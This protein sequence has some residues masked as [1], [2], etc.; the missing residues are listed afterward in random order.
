MKAIS[1]SVFLTAFLA[2]ACIAEGDHGRLLR[3]GGKDKKPKHDEKY[4]VDQ[5]VSNLT[6]IRNQIA[7]IGGLDGIL[8]AL[9]T[10]QERAHEVSRTD[11]EGDSILSPLLRYLRKKTSSLEYLKQVTESLSS[12]NSLLLQL[13]SFGGLFSLLGAFMTGGAGTGTVD[14]VQGTTVIEHVSGEVVG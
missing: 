2:L 6:S 9:R 13:K 8:R 4:Y 1:T 7:P 5:I 11:P 14:G 10:Y 12:L 3:H